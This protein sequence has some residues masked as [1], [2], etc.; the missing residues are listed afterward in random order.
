VLATVKAK[1]LIIHGDN[2]D[3][4]PVFNAW[5]MYNHI[6]KSHLWV[7]PNGGHSPPGDP[8]NQ[9]DFVRRT[10]QFLKGEWDKK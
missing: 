1:A 4:A 5:E 7:I 10:V 3:I 6:P 9:A 2:D 8:V